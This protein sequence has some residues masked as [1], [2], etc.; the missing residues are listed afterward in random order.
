MKVIGIICAKGKSTRFPGKNKHVHK[1][2]PLFWHS[3]RPLLESKLVDDVY[4]AT[5]S[6]D[7]AE[8]CKTKDVQTVYRGINANFTDEPLMGVLNFCIKSVDKEYD[9]VI[10]IMANCPNHSTDDVDGA[11]AKFRDNSELKEVR[12]FDKQGIETGLLLF[13]SNIVK[14]NLSVSSHIGS[15]LTEG[16]EVH[17]K[18]DLRY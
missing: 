6:Q 14:S 13:D 18:E 1:G 9:A 5:D 3:V 8:Y 12:G 4:V 17:Y 11:I 16:Y 2:V 7:I 10:T 15:V